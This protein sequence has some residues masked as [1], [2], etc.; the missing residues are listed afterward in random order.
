MSLRIDILNIEEPLIEFGNSGVNFNPKSGLAEFGPLSLSF[1]AAHQLQVRVGLVGPEEV[2]AN[3]RKWFSRCRSYISSGH[4]NKMLHP[5]FPGFESIFRASL[6]L[7]NI[8]E[9]VFDT[10]ELEDAFSQKPQDRYDAIQVLYENGIRKLAEASMPPHVIVVCISDQI[11]TNCRTRTVSRLSKQERAILSK[12]EQGQQAL[13]GEFS[14]LLEV[15]DTLLR[16]DFRRALKARAMR[17]GK[18][19]QIGTNNLFLDSEGN[20]DPA[21]RAWNVCLALFYKAG[22]LPWRLKTLSEDTCYVGISFHQLRTRQRHVVFPSLAQAFPATG[23]GFILRGDT[24]SIDRN[25]D[26]RNPHLNEYQAGEL[27]KNIISEYRNRIGHHPTRVVLY[28]TSKFDQ[29]EEHGFKSALS[30]IPLVEMVN[31]RS[32]EFR[33]VRTGN[34]PPTRGTVVTINENTHFLFT[35]GYFDYWNT[36]MGAHI[37]VPYEINLSEGTDPIRTCSEILGLTKLNWNTA[38]MFTGVPIPISFSREVGSIISH[39]MDLTSNEEIRPNPS[40][41]FYM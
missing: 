7:S 39:Y 5:D 41:R 16:Q 36:Y 25:S 26:D 40:Y 33:L 4:E 18:P 12:Q 21:T 37:P 13:P 3:A 31:L 29:A 1:G 10:N 14:E 8:W 38:R 22:G 9:S 6:E 32:S 17:I 23:E 28:K 15:E 2:V 30:G 35:N 24:V 11:Y 34:Y 19:I 20:Q 27:A